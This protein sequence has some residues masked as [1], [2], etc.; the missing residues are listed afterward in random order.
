LVIAVDSVKIRY[1]T[2]V[3]VALLSFHKHL[4]DTETGALTCKPRVTMQKTR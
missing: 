4:S 3:H 1:G 2:I